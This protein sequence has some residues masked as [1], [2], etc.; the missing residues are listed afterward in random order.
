[1]KK[2]LLFIFLLLPY[3]SAFA[4]KDTLVVSENSI[5]LI[6]RRYFQQ[7]EDPTKKLT[8]GDII[9]C[10]NFA[11]SKSALPSL[12]VSNPVVWSKMLIKKKSIQANIPVTIGSTI[13]DSFDIYYINQP[14]KKTI[15]LEPEQSEITYFS[16]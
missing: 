8:I 7:V 13:I 15:H 2:H 9:A 3:C 11:D 16:P 4:G 5:E 14:D 6:N 12:K 10:T 1:M